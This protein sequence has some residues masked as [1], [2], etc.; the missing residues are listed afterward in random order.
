MVADSVEDWV[1]E[2]EAK[3]QK[4][5]MGKQIDFFKLEKAMEEGPLGLFASAV[6]KTGFTKKARSGYL[7]IVS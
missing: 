4:E 5:K 6:K 1:K 7:F 3:Y 2:E